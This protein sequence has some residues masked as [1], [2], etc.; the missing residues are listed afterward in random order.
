MTISANVDRSK[1][2]YLEQQKCN[3]SARSFQG[4]SCS[5]GRRL[6]IQALLMR[7]QSAPFRSRNGIQNAYF[8]S[9]SIELIHMS[10][11]TL[12]EVQNFPTLP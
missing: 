11:A 8:P 7:Q 1:T 10:L 5:Q 9:I 12:T 3:A 2:R 6:S 4:P